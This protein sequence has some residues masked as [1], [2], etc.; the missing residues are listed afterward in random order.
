[1]ARFLENFSWIR[2]LRLLNTLGFNAWSF[3]LFHCSGGSKLLNALFAFRSQ[4]PFFNCIYLFIFIVVQV[5]F[6][7]FSPH[8]SPTPQPSPP[9]SRFHPCPPPPL[10]SMCPLSW[11]LQTSHPFPLKIPPLSP[12]VT[13]SLFSISV[14]LVIFC[15]IV[16]FVDYHMISPLTGT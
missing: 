4:I 6:S 13:V 11:F 3:V 16:C 10:L 1:M 7:A 5:Q 15:L 8:P 12:L 14:S 2:F 9:P